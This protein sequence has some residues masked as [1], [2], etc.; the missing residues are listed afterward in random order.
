MDAAQWWADNNARYWRTRALLLAHVASEGPVRLLDGRL[1]GYMPDGNAWDS[2]GVARDFP[3]LIRAAEAT[4]TG[5]KET[6]ERVLDMVLEELPDLAYEVKL[7]VDATA[8][9]AVIRAGGE[10]ADKLL[11]HRVAKNKLG[12]R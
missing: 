3:A 8:A 7:T 5:P 1:V 4:F 6:V 10:A 11:P 12:V 9:N 2:E